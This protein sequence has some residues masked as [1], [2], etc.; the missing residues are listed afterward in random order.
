MPI[1]F[2]KLKRYQIIQIQVRVALAM[3]KCQTE[4]K[5]ITVC[6]VSDNFSFDNLE[7]LNE[8]YR[9]LHTLREAPACCENAKRV[10]F[11]MIRQYKKFLHGFSHS[12]QRKLNGFVY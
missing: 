8:G 5:N 10:V 6:Q 3:R 2:F 7:R 12:L 11:A 4:G 1:T 9:V